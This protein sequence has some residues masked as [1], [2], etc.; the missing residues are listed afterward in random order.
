MKKQQFFGLGK[1]AGVLVL[2]V[3]VL[4]SSCSK[5]GSEDEVTPPPVPGFTPPVANLGFATL[6]DGT[7]GGSAGQVVEA[8][9][10][11][12]LR[13]LLES[14]QPVVVTLNRR[15]YNGEKGGSI[16]VGSNKTLVGIGANAFLDG[17]GLSIIGQ[18][19]V[20]V[21][22]VTITL[23]SVTN[24]DDPA[25]YSPTGDE[26]RPQIL[27]NGGDLIRIQNSVNIWVDHCTF[28]NEDPLVQTNQDLYDGCVDVTGNSALITIS[29]NIFR[30]AH[31]TSLI[32]SSD[33]DNFDRRIT[34]HHNMFSNISQRI[35]SYRF[36]TGH[37]VNNYFVNIRSTGINSRMGACV[38]VENNVFE[39]A[40]SPL[41]TSGPPLGNFQVSNNSFT[42]TT[43]INPPTT[44]N[45][46][47]TIP[48]TFI[49]DPVADVKQKVMAGAGAGKL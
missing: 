7:T 43:G 3:V 40:R 15:I 47:A 30:D 19:N 32:G 11:N 10:F 8:T 13:N 17:I 12:S 41:I 39:N 2:A 5:N 18:R 29:W 35:P 28:Y 37:V 31:K 4:L 26:G 44:S 22:N 6:G 38:R 21:R 23:N 27:V 14:S 46:T 25:V 16:R 48:Y 1:M 42:G 9:D 49:P 20:I 24:R 33:S 45:C 36:G 34:Y